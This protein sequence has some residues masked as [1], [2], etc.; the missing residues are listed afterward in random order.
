MIIEGY[1]RWLWNIIIGITT[2]VAKE[3]LFI[4]KHCIH[5]KKGICELCG[6]ILKAKSRVHYIEDKH[7]ISIGGCPERKW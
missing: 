2:A 6:C 3:R 4:C 7:G 5:N 1:S